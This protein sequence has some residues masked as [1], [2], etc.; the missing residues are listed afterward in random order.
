V[1]AV[2]D[3]SDAQLALREARSVATQARS[4]AAERAQD[5]TRNEK[6]AAQEY[7]SRVQLQA[8]RTQAEVARA[9]LAGADARVAQ[10]QRQVE[11]ATVRAP[12]DA[13]VLEQK[14]AAGATVRAGEPLFQLFGS[15]EMVLVARAP[16]ALVGR[17]MVGQGAVARWG[18]LRLPTS[19]KRVSPVL[20]ATSRS[21]DVHL[22]VPGGLAGLPGAALTVELEQAQAAQLRVPAQAVQLAG[23]DAFVYVVEDARAKRR[24]IRVGAQQ[25]GSAYVDSGLREGETV[26][27]EGAS[28]LR[29]DAPVQVAPAAHVRAAAPGSPVGAR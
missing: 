7:I 6:L 22:A 12:F 1:L 15:G 13:V 26:V 21:F 11:K 19:V 27:V 5:L 4:L 18:E 29:H 20:S 24:S 28:F 9:Q 25:A 23:D 8:S 14:V 17:I 16:Q 2:L 3:D 10:A